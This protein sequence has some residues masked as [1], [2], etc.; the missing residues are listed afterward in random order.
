MS[1]TENTNGR[2]RL[3][4]ASRGSLFVSLTLVA[5]VAVAVAQT[6]ARGT[7][8][9]PIAQTGASEAD[10]AL[11]R[12][13][14]AVCTER[15][16]D[17]R[18][19]VP[20]DVMQARANLPARNAEVQASAARAARLLSLAKQLAAESLT[21]LMREAS[22]A[23]GARRAALS[24]IEAVRRIKLEVSLRDN[25]SI[26]YLDPRTIRFGTI[27]IASLP[28]D[29]G[30]VSVMA[31]ELTHAADGARGSLAPVFRRVARRAEASAALGHL[32][33]RRG[34]ELTCDLVGVMA[35]RLYVARNA[36]D[37]ST[38]RRAA[39]ALEHNCVEHDETDAEHLSPRQTL[40]AML[41]LTPAL[42]AEVTG[43]AE[44]DETNAPLNHS[45]T[46]PRRDKNQPRARRQPARRRRPSM[47]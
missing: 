37:E 40:R 5:C 7:V 27:F 9:P 47:R 6:G 17:P 41:A 34:E 12:A 32:N 15:E 18:A 21:E 11:A 46:A 23:E 42:A 2:R 1:R 20:I 38:S 3:T 25:A 4:C 14:E 39:R 26:V 16:L 45:S 36:T 13:A 28:S 35:A 10:D 30:M 44:A 31:H 43:E 8:G 33:A 19:S 29:E 22:V 24:R